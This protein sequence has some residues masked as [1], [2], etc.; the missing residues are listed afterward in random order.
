[1]YNELTG[2]PSPFYSQRPPSTGQR[3]SPPIG[4][5]S[6]AYASDQHNNSRQIIINDYYTSQQMQN[7]PGVTQ[8][9]HLPQNAIGQP[10]IDSLKRNSGPTNV[11]VPGNSPIYGNLPQRQD[12]VYR[13][14][15]SPSCPPHQQQRQG[16][17]QRANAN[18]KLFS[19]FN[20]LI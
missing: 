3:G 5:P 14:S 6:S 16:V 11:P 9:P 7:P 10:R 18:R 13:Q 4:H 17:I 2:S 15:P 12:I 1:M 19:L 8:N 20:I